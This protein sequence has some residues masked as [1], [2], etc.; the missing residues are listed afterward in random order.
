MKPFHH[1]IWKASTSDEKSYYDCIY[2]LLQIGMQW[3]CNIL[4][5]S[6]ND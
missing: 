1:H 3:T 5:T 2:R 4:H 6:S